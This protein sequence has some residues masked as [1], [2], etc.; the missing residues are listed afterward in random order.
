[1]HVACVPRPPCLSAGPI[2]I[3]CLL[4]DDA[5]NMKRQ[6]ICHRG[7]CSCW[8]GFYVLV[9]FHAAPGDTTVVSGNLVRDW[10]TLWHLLSSRPAFATSLAG[11]VFLDIINEPDGL[12]L[13]YR[14]SGGPLLLVWLVVI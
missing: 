6:Q 7:V 5:V 1:M 11:R 4:V 8:Q 14:H 2:P 12:G 10:Q 13:R 3:L 9:D